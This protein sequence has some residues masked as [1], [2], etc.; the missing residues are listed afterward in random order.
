MPDPI[1]LAVATALAVRTAEAAVSAGPAAWQ[2][3]V[4]LVRGRFAEAPAAQQALEAAQ[5]QPD[6]ADSVQAL[7]GALDD[8]TS[9]DR[10]FDAELRALWAQV[11]SVVH[12]DGTVINHNSG[13]VTGSLLQGRNV[14]FNGQLHFGGSTDGRG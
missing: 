1:T 6:D 11:G 9:N 4:R 5:A 3:L 8:V 10:S 14:T 13:T 12:E 2:S 7:A